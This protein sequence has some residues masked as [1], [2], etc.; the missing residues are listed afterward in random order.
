MRGWRPTISSIRRGLE[1]A[2]AADDHVLDP[3]DDA[4]ITLFVE[5]AEVAGAVEAVGGERHRRRF[6]IVQVAVGLVGAAPLDLAR[7][8]GGQGLTELVDEAHLAFVLGAADRGQPL[9]LAVVEVGRGRD[10]AIGRAIDAEDLAR[11]VLLDL[12]ADVGTERRTGIDEAAETR[13]S[14]RWVGP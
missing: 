10:A 9:L 14:R 4:Q 13:R 3:A 5:A 6:G 8:A 7:D 11:H 2:A 1:V 12:A